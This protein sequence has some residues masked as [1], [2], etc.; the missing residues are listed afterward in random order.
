M[1]GKNLFKYKCDTCNAWHFESLKSVYRSLKTTSALLSNLIVIAEE[2]HKEFSIALDY[3]NNDL[4][5]L[6]SLLELDYAI[7]D[8]PKEMIE[9]EITEEDELDEDEDEDDSL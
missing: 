3:I 7:D 8:D 1:T 5:L 4:H 6:Q 2:N 9:L